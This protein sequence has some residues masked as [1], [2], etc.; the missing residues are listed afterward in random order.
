MEAELASPPLP[1]GLE[2]IWRAYWR[3]RKRKAG[4]GFGSVPI[5][6]PDIDAFVRHT[7]SELVPWEVEFIEVIDDLFMAEQARRSAKGRG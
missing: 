4:N 2:Y 3:I 1:K 7:R 6:W 5:E